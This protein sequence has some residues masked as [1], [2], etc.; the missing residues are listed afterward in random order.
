MCSQVWTPRTPHLCAH[1]WTPLAP[2]LCALS[3]VGA[4]AAPRLGA[5]ALPAA[6]RARAC[7]VVPIFGRGGRGGGSGGGGGAGAHSGDLSHA[8]F[9]ADDD[10]GDSKSRHKAG[11]LGAGDGHLRG[12]GDVDVWR[13]GC[14]SV[15]QWRSGDAERNH[16]GGRLGDHDRLTV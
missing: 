3:T 13:R 4:A 12:C 2:H 1:V 7:A 8:E 15:E 14:E 16:N 6:T 11:R 10:A 9:P 5:E